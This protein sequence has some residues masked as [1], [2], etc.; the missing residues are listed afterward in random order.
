[1]FVLLHK[2]YNHSN[3]RT[4]VALGKRA[5]KKGGAYYMSIK[6]ET[7]VY[8][9]CDNCGNYYATWAATQKE[10]IITLRKEGWTFGKKSLCPMCNS[11]FKPRKKDAQ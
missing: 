10:V 9:E 4:V 11:T 1:M 6:T 7:Q 8:V 3:A 5:I 2:A